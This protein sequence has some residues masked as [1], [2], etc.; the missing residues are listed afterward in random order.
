MKIRILFFSFCYLPE[1]QL[2]AQYYFYD[3]N[4]MKVMLFMK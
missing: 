4:I 2:K 3:G 1:A